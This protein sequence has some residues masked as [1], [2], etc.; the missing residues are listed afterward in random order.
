[1]RKI[2][3]L[4]VA[5][6]LAFG[7]V[8]Q[9]GAAVKFNASGHWRVLFNFNHDTDFNDENT[10][11]TFT[12]SN[13]IRILFSAEANEFVKGSWE[14]QAGQWVWGSG[15]NSPSYNITTNTYTAGGGAP[16]DTASENFKTRLA[17]LTVKI[18]NTPLTVNSGIQQLNLPGAVAGN[19]IFANRVAGVSAV[20]KVTDD[21]SLTAFWARPYY[22][23]AGNA[24]HNSVDFFGLIAGIKVASV[25]ISPYYVYGNAGNDSF[26]GGTFPAAQPWA[27]GN[28][29]EDTDFHIVGLAL[30]ANPTPELAVKLDAIYGAAKNDSSGSINA[31]AP[32]TRFRDFDT[33]GFFLALGVDYKLGFGT[34]GLVAWYSSGMDDDGDGVIPSFNSGGNGF[35]PTRLGTAGGNNLWTGY[36]AITGTGVG[37]YGIG[38]QVKDIKTADKL[39]HVFRAFYIKGTN[40]EKYGEWGDY[41]G[42]DEDLSFFELNFDSV[43]QLVDNLQVKLDLGYI[44]P[45]D[46]GDDDDLDDG[47]NARLWLSFD[48]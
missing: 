25:S 46:S 27:G 43:Y 22:N 38:L 44:I 30:T 40:D 13:R 29:D 18:P 11:D 34:P 47:F 15:Q 42:L 12:G 7:L 39:S 28:L 5:A 36:N 35:A 24:N 41:K 33:K 21:V 20:A 26:G 8:S 32:G 6:M 48:F 31:A 14:F 37:T 10:E 23:T 2:S 4:L 45:H 19:P 17:W 3:I 9:A 16:L 1:M